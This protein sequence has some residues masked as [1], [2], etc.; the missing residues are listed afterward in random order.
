MKFSA[1][2]AAATLLAAPVFADGHATGDAEAGEKVYKKCKSC[3]MIV[4]GDNVVQKGGRTGPNLFGLYPRV[5]GGEEGFKYSKPL[6]LLGEDE[7]NT[8]NEEEFVAWLMDPSKYLKEKTDDPK[9][10]SKM[11]YKL[12]KEED[13]R[14]LWAYLVSVGPEVTAEASN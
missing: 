10:R 12:K 13:A 8:W 1:L 14:N 7:A 11:S 9:A 4:D 5:I 3:H 6:A 2:V